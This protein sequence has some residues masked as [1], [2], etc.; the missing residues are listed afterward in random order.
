MAEEKPKAPPIR[1]VLVVSA[2]PDDPEFG[3]GATIGKFARDGVDV[4]Y[5]VVTDGSQ[6]GE[7]PHVPDEELTATR[8]Q[9]QRSAAAKLGVKDVT[10]LGFKDGHLVANTDLRKAITSEIRRH[11][12]DLVLTHNPTRLLLAQ[13]IGAFHPD[14][15]AVGE[16]T[17]AAVYPDARN[18]RAYRE[19]LAEGLEPHKVREVWV[20]G[21]NESDHFV[22]AT[23]DLME[24]KIEAILCHRSQFEKPGME[25]GAPGKWIRDRMKAVGEK[26]GFE[27]AE[28]FRRLETA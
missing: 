9:E 19:L 17:L 12:P 15:L 8:Y 16:A 26:A 7:N 14:H 3:F 1:T 2:H 21:F 4:F 23:P 27:Y 6:G 28:G 25:E 13:G 24:L 5:C 11:K 18:P 20:S 22:E 10:F